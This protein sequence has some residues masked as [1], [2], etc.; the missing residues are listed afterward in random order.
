MHA[1]RAVEPA[2]EVLLLGQF[3]IVEASGQYF[4]ASQIAHVPALPVN[5][6]LHVHAAI[7][8]DPATEVELEGHGVVV[9]ESGQ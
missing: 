2:A 6:A 7:D 1:D 9:A 3:V 5:P 4:P 8:D